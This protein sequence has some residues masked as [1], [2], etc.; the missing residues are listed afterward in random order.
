MTGREA[1]ECVLQTRGSR[2]GLLGSRAAMLHA[3]MCYTHPVEQTVD[4]AGLILAS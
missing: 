1:M 3:I 2:T 4:S